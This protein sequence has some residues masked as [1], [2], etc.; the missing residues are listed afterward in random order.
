MSL[1]WVAV[2]LE[3]RQRAA[4]EGGLA[5]GSQGI[6]ARVL[7]RPQG[8]FVE[9]PE[10]REEEALRLSRRR[11]DMVAVRLLP[12]ELELP[13]MGL[14]RLRDPETGVH[15][16]GI[17]GGGGRAFDRD[18]AGGLD[19]GGR[20]QDPGGFGQDDQGDVVRNFDS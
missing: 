9:V 3:D 19:D 5:L 18:S 12:P 6:D 17:A 20:S 15:T 8:F 7:R 10:E 1:G 13:E 4:E 16:G 11:H 14:V 2:A